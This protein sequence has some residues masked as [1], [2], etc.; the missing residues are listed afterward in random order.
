MVLPPAR[1]PRH[2]LA[3]ALVATFVAA[4]AG[5]GGG[6]GEADVASGLRHAS[7]RVRADVAAPLDADTG[8]AGV[9]GEAATVA[10]DRPFRL[11]VE[12][13]GVGAAEAG[14]AVPL[15]LQVRRNGGPWTP[16]P[17]ADHPYPDEIA[18]P[19]VSVVEAP[20]YADGA[21]TGDLLTGSELPFRPGSGV[22]LDS[23]RRR[24]SRTAPTG[25]GRGR[26]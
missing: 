21:P 14:D 16:V 17:A 26:W 3:A 23:V 15:R 13:E 10:A 5:C 11:R 9:E 6:D 18:S 12:L 24:G 19:R 2:L 8:W 4:L 25:S 22:S 7:F 20:S 1:L